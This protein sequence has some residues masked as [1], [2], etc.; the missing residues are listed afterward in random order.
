MVLNS[1][2]LLVAMSIVKSAI[3]IKMT[4]D[5][6]NKKYYCCITQVETPVRKLFCGY[7]KTC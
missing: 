3:F 2:K 6:G 4:N 5:V 7:R 1:L